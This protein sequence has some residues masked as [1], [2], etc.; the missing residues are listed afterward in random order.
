MPKPLTERSMRR[1]KALRDL[2]SENPS[3]YFRASQKAAFQHH[4]QNPDQPWRRLMRSAHLTSPAGRGSQLS[5]ASA[6][7]ETGGVTAGKIKAVIL[8]A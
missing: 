5:T 6:I 4:M 8:A 2:R 1:R 7:V 3:Q